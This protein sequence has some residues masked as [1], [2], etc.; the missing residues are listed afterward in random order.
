MKRTAAKAKASKTYASD[1]FPNTASV[2]SWSS[3]KA[4]RKSVAIVV[5]VVLVPRL[6]ASR[7]SAVDLSK[8][9]KR[10]EKK[11]DISD[12]RRKLNMSLKKKGC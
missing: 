3:F 10:G 11:L 8:E 9:K 12:I 7:I 1:H 2:I 4:H 6:H 5:D